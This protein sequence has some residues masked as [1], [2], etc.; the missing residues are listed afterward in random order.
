MRKKS[1]TKSIEKDLLQTR[2]TE[3]RRYLPEDYIS[4]IGN[5]KSNLTFTNH[6]MP[7][8]RLYLKKHLNMSRKNTHPEL[9]SDFENVWYASQYF[10]AKMLAVYW[11]DMQ[12]VDFLVE[13][14]EQ[15]FSWANAIDNWAHSD[16]LCSIYARVY[17]LDQQRAHRQYQIWSR[18]KN[19]WLRRCSMVGTFYYSR[20]RK[21]QPRFNKVWGL[22]KT[23]LNAKEYYVQKGVGWTIRE[24]Y[25]VYPKETRALL[26]AHIR[27][28]TPIAWVAAS[29]KL[30]LKE[31]K[32]LLQMRKCRIT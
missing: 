18:E 13:K 19:S 30:P 2:P 7:M 3:V 28:I 23:N 11:L 32:E 21:K 15:I 5:E 25:N 9:Y 1:F 20:L 4:G 16:S 26:H 31:K 29:E 12:S 24:M 27:D 17:E 22:V 6:S 10:E 8:L 14:H